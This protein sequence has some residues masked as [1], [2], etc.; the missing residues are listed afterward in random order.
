M[1]VIIKNCRL[2]LFQMYLGLRDMS[3]YDATMYSKVN[4]VGAAAG[5]MPPAQPARRKWKSGRS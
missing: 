3:E 2:F 1:L 4:D 5:K